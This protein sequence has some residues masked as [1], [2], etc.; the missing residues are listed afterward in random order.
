MWKLASIPLQLKIH[1]VCPV[2]YSSSVFVLLLY[3][4]V[5]IDNIDKNPPSLI[6]YKPTLTL[7][8]L[9]TAVAAES[10][11]TTLLILGSGGEPAIGSVVTSVGSHSPPPAVLQILSSGDIPGSY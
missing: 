3:I 6:M 11:T 7:A 4:P 10:Y 8:L 2:P 5:D 1:Y 9:A